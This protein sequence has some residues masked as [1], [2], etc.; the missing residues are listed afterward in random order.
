VNLHVYH[1]S[2]NNPITYID[3]DGRDGNSFL[4]R[5]ENLANSVDQF[6]SENKEA[7]LVIAA[8]GT[9]IVAG[10]LLKGGG[11][12]GGVALSGGTGGL[13]TPA[14][15]ALAVAGVSAGGVMEAAGAGM[16]I[17]GLAMLAS[18]NNHESSGGSRS[19]PQTQ[20]NPN[21]TLVEKNSN[22]TVRRV[23]QYDDNGNILREIRPEGSHGIKGPTVKEPT[24]NTNPNTGQTFQNGW[25]YRPATD[26]E[27]NLLK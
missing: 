13:G 15:V 16:L 24:L 25:N 18:N 21:Q 6:I 4:G 26:A 20:G 5:L 2:F 1:Y 9:L 27:I 7:L 10:N 23:T 17:A 3:P 11:V 19:S 12:A 8:G 22:G 14:G